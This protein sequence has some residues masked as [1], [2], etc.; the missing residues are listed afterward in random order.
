MTFTA[1]Q[2]A[3]W[4]E[5]F[6][7]PFLRVGAMTVAAPVFGSQLVPPRARLVLALALTLTLA[8]LLPPVPEMT[9]F[10]PVWW[11]AVVQQILIGM[12]LGFVLQVVFE[13]VVL[14]AQIIAM[15]AGL[16][17]AQLNDPLRGTQTTVLS[18]YF[19]ILSTLLFLALGGH[20]TLISFTAES[21]RVLPVGAVAVDGGLARIVAGFGVDMFAGAMRIALP[22]TMAVLLVNLS[23]GVI[24][25]SAPSLNLFAIGLPVALLFGLALLPLTLDAFSGAFV[26]MLDRAWALFDRVLTS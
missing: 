4:L 14:G 11:G 8:P 17:F 25:R 23:F 2:I 26:T 6:F 5:A 21:F 3:E 24:S 12:V 7:W 22:V 16:G 10:S 18:Q 1:V 19:L 20:L 13:A 9:T 15:G